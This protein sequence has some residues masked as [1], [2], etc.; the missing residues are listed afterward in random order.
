MQADS[1]LTQATTATT[2]MYHHYC[3][4]QELALAAAS[5]E[6]VLSLH[7]RDQSE[8]RGAWVRSRRDARIRA[9]LLCTVQA[10]ITSIQVML[11]LLHCNS[12]LIVTIRRS[13]DCEATEQPTLELTLLTLRMCV[14]VCKSAIKC[15]VAALLLH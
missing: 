8:A 12:I 5:A 10:C 6:I 11:L 13:L 3:T 4:A 1:A 2:A 14:R 9:D 7:D 15:S